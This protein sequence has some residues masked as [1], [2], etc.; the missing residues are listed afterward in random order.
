M[1][2]RTHRSP[3][4]LTLA[5][6]LLVGPKKAMSASGCGW[7]LNSARLA[8]LRLITRMWPGG[9]GKGEGTTAWVE[10]LEGWLRTVVAHTHR[11]LTK[12][13]CTRL[14]SARR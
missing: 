12:L 13:S 6:R 9:F 1:M 10:G 11:R 14:L 3:A 5:S 2:C 4:L 7:P 8:V